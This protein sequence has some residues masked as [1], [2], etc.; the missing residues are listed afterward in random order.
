MHEIEQEVAN[1]NHIETVTI[2]SSRFNSK[3]SEI[4]ANLKMSSG[5]NS[6]IIS[7][8]IETGNDGNV[9]PIH[10]FRILFPKMKKKTWLQQK[11]NAL[12]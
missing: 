6:T 10:I 3:Q 9:M 4:M 1:E 5:Q 7:Y 11:L 2:N 12:S 8:K